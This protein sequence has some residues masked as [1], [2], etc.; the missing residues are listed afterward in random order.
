[1]EA[2]HPLEAA[3]ALQPSSALIFANGEAADGA[4]VRRTLARAGAALIVAVD[5]G[6]RV[7]ARFGVRVQVV[8]GDMDSLAAPELEAL[9]AAGAEVHRHPAEKDETDLELAL[10]FVAA[11]GIRYIRVLGA[12]GGRLDQT[13]SN[14]YLLALPEL[15]GFDVRLVDGVQESWL[16]HP[17][18]NVVAGAPGDT[19]SLLPLSDAVYGVR[20]ANLQYPLRDET[21]TF[22]PARG[23]SNVMQADEAKVWFREGRLLAVYTLGRA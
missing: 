10:K 11:Q 8:I 15:A 17:G 13:V 5:G 2:P 23:I 7:A 16:M 21:L 18:E 20:T 22:G 14:I 9:A 19:L 4:L 6:A 1:M 12:M 3:D